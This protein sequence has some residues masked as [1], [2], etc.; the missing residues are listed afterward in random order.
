MNLTAPTTRLSRLSRSMLLFVMVFFAL[1]QQSIFTLQN[2]RS[3][4]TFMIA[5]R[6]GDGVPS[7]HTFTVNSTGDWDG[8]CDGPLD[9]TEPVDGSEGDC[10]LR[11]AIQAAN[12]SLGFDLINFNIPT[13]RCDMSGVCTISLMSSLPSVSDARING[14]SQPGAMRNTAEQGTNAILKIELKGPRGIPNPPDIGG[15]GCSEN[16][17]VEGLTI[18]SFPSNA[19]TWQG[20]GNKV[21]GCFIGTDVTGTIALPN[22][23]DG[24][25]AITLAYGNSNLIGGDPA[26]RNLISGNLGDGIAFHGIGGDLTSNDNRILNNLIGVQADGISPLGNAGNGILFRNAPGPIHDNQIANNVIAF[27]IGVGINIAKAAQA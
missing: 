23:A 11:E 12:Q 2:Y 13:D 21:L 27:N 25:P 5:S 19:I 20:G 3:A 9:G 15:I 1:S 24:R 6:G 18:N 26:D 7:N 14:Y 17:I 10:T 16:V 22:G 8:P 4:A